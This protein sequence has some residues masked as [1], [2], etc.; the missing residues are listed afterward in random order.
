MKENILT[1]TFLR[2]RDRLKVVASAIARD[3]DEAEDI[4]HDSFCKLWMNYRSIQ[5]PTEVARV[6]YATVRN[7]AIDSRRRSRLH[8]SER[9]G[10]IPDFPADTESEEIRE[11]EET[12]RQALKTARRILKDRQYEVFILHDVENLPYPDIAERL[13][14]TQENVR[15]ILS[16]AR[17]ALRQELITNLKYET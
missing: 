6:S 13:D 15:A 8:P 7:V 9:L 3:P 10:E 4:L 11:R 1:S 14:L 5:D 12:C 17:R 16:R 2:L